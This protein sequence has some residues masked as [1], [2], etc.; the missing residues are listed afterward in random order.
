MLPHI[1]IRGRGLDEI[2]EEDILILTA[3]HHTAAGESRL[4]IFRQN[5]EVMDDMATAVEAGEMPRIALVVT[6]PLDVLTEYLVAAVGGPTGRGDGLRHVT[7]HA[8]AHATH[9]RGVR[10]APAQRARVG[11]R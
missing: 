5:L 6:N 3:G 8:A 10:G 1:E 2:E 11:G 4:D 7:R 9:R